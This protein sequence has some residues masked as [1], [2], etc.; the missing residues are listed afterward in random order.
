MIDNYLI[1]NEEEIRVL[2]EKY[3]TKAISEDEKHKLLD[4]LDENPRLRQEFI[5]TQNVEGLISWMPTP[6]EKR[7]S[8]IR[9][10]KRISAIAAAIL[11]I[12][13]TTLFINAQINKNRES[14]V[15]TYQE[16]YVP[17]GQRA[18]ITLSDGTNVW[19]NSNSRLT[20]DTFSRNERRVRLNGEG[21][22]QVSHDEKRPFY[23]ETDK[24]QVRVLGTRFNLFAYSKS[25]YSQTTLFEGSVKV[26]SL[27]DETKAVTIKPNEQITFK[28]DGS[29]EI[30]CM[31][32]LDCLSWTDGIY[33]F[34][35]Q[36]MTEI[37][38]KLEMYYD[39][40]IELLNTRLGEYRFSG[41]FYQRDS[42]LIILKALQEI[43]SFTFTVDEAS[44]HIYIQ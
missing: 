32:D 34:D 36:K 6:S 27:T 26:N 7:K 9:I 16:I 3:F 2:I 41:K 29:M 38:A 25:G 18:S 15:L 1:M 4:A 8:I 31:E 28:E 40:D 5:D 17:T 22:F 35:D 42:I 20:T 14:D 39:F 19:L 37:L 33:S 21:Y 10:V 44:R 43:H 23:V 13:A 11:L 12:M 30:S 24:V